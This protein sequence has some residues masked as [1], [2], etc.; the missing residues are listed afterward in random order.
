LGEQHHGV[1][2]RWAAPL[3]FQMEEVMGLLSGLKPGEHIQF[4]DGRISNGVAV[5]HVSC[6][7]L[8]VEGGEHLHWKDVLTEQ[9]YVRFLQ[10]PVRKLRNRRHRT[11]KQSTA[12]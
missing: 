6:F 1:A 11:F 4:E 2:Q 12:A 3:S 8:D 9:E 7:L 5:V 10:D